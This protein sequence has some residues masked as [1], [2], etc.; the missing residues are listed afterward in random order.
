MIKC[1]FNVGEI[2]NNGRA[3]EGNPRKYVVIINISKLKINTTDMRG[4][5][6]EFSIHAQDRLK[7]VGT[8]SLK[9]LF[10]LQDGKNEIYLEGDKK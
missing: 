2:I 9:K 3:S 4:N 7:K 8:I 1:N 6:I 5:M 10:K